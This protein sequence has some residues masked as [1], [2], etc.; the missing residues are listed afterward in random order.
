VFVTSNGSAW[1]RPRV[2]QSDHPIM[3]E[4]SATDAWND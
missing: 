4:I 1:T 2:R 3:T